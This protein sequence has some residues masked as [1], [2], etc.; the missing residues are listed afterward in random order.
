MRASSVVVLAQALD[1]GLRLSK[2]RTKDPSIFKIDPDLP[3]LGPH[4]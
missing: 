1:D 2:A 4:T 3:I